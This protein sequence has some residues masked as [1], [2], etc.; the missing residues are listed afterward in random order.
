MLFHNTSR[1]VY[2]ILCHPVPCYTGNDANSAPQ[3]ATVQQ[4]SQRFNYPHFIH[5]CCGWAQK[6]VLQNIDA[7][8]RLFVHACACAETPAVIQGTEA[9]EHTTYKE[10]LAVTCCGAVLLLC[11]LAEACHMLCLAT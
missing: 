10:N 3:T 1:Y 7:G 8:G 11:S 4:L 5:P 9:A 6:T 2:V